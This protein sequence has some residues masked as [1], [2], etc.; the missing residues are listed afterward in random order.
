[1]A[2]GTSGQTGSNAT[3][4][5]KGGTSVRVYP[6]TNE[7]FVS[8]GYGNSRIM[9]YDADTGQFKRMWGAFG[10]KPLDKDQRPVVEPSKPTELCPMV[11]GIWST[12]QQFALPLDIK[13]SNDGLAYVADRGNKR[14][15]VFTPEGK[16][17]AEQFV[18]ADSK[19]PF[20]GKVCGIL[21]RS[22]ATI[23]VCFGVT[24]RLRLES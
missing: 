6:K 9:V 8:D 21:S 10:D 1:M 17:V 20:A 23:F 12:Y 16:F 19:F 14:V 15:Q 5:L 22:G 18:G 2:I 24:G 4:I 13:L 11:C 7:V 3:E